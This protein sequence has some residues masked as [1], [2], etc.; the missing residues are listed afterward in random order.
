MLL[1]TQEASGNPHS[2]SVINP[3]PGSTRG[4][5]ARPTH[6]IAGT[7]TPPGISPLA[8]SSNYHKA[9]DTDADTSLFFPGGSQA[10]TVSSRSGKL[11][12]AGR[13]TENSPGYS[14]PQRRWCDSPAKRKYDEILDSQE[15]DSLGSQVISP[16][17]S[18]GLTQNLAAMSPPVAMPPQS[19][20]RIK[21]MNPVLGRSQ[22]NAI[23]KVTTP[24]ISS[25][26]HLKQSPIPMSVGS[27][28]RQVEL[29]TSPSRTR[30]IATTPPKASIATNSPKAIF[31][32]ADDWEVIFEN[33]DPFSD[34]E[35]ADDEPWRRPARANQATKLGQS[36]QPRLNLQP[37]DNSLALRLALASRIPIKS[38]RRPY[39]SRNARD[40]LRH[41]GRWDGFREFG[42][43]IHIEYMTSALG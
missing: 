14:I 7:P 30:R 37:A 31:E 16:R 24:S 4:S 40:F 29:T 35:E 19:G 9:F 17:S 42:L 32:G 15:P 12:Y 25:P 36:T 3:L 6:S 22:T 8:S 18:P 39:L 20:K 13:N 26:T 23:F 38:M 10:T 5:L 41:T 21:A 34:V 27:P 1:S 2:A 33:Y 28:R 11:L 43:W